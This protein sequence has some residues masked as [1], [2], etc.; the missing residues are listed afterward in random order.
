MRGLEPISVA[1]SQ[2]LG[3]FFSSP[4]NTVVY[5][6]LKDFQEN[7]PYLGRSS[8]FL[9]LMLHIHQKQVLW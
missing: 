5:D 6:M 1:S 4:L 8:Q 7:E 9:M 2:L 3:R